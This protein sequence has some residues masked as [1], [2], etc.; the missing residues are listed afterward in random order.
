VWRGGKLREVP[1]TIGEFKDE[2]PT[3]VAKSGK[4]EVKPGKYGLALVDLT[5]EQ[6][7]QIKVTSGVLVDG[8]EGVA[9][10]AG[11]SP[12]DV[13]LRVNNIEVASVKA[14]GE[15]VAKLDAKKPVALLVKDE[16]GTR[17]ITLRP[18]TE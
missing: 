2:T 18:D 14:F 4:P 13:I 16:N 12:G 6:K 10:A 5:A 3:K 17:F 15:A 11:I 8:V 7:K 9:Q 1:I